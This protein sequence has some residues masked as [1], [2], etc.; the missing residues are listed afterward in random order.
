MWASG[1]T[2]WVQESVLATPPLVDF[3]AD[4][5]LPRWQ[6]L[7]IVGGC[8]V[9]MWALERLSWLVWWR[10][11]LDHGR[12]PRHR[13][14]STLPAHTTTQPA[15]RATAPNWQL[16]ARRALSRTAPG[17]PGSPGAA[18]RSRR[19]ADS[20]D[21]FMTTQPA[22]DPTAAQAAPGCGRI[23]QGQSVHAAPPA[24]ASM[25]GGTCTSR[26]VAST[27]VT[28]SSGSR[29]SAAPPIR[30]PSFD[31]ARPPPYQRAP[32]DSSYDLPAADFADARGP[33][34]SRDGS[35]A[36]VDEEG[37][38]RRDQRRA[39]RHAARRAAREAEVSDPRLRAARDLQHLTNMGFEEAEAATALASS[40][41]QLQAA[42]DLLTS[43]RAP[44]G[45][46]Q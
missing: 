40:D 27:V 22:T 17:S 46:G 7:C 45:V 35:T 11:V 8:A 33:S 43:S 4:V 10:C 3:G 42:L 26:G 39:E 21:P 28:P 12:P 38:V 6:V 5:F 20:C 16:S 34:V 18:R 15:A 29:T 23:S 44:E 31:D 2:R 36:G 37:R 14:A 13:R 19:Q 30:Q 41:G 9:L 32:S 25:G 24:M 1:V